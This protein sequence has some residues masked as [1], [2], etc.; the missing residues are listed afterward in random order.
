MTSCCCAAPSS[1]RRR[2]GLSDGSREPRSRRRC[3]ESSSTRATR[4]SRPAT[5][6]SASNSRTI[7]QGPGRTRARAPALHPV[8]SNVDVDCG[9]PVR[10]HL[11]FAGFLLR[12]NSRLKKAEDLLADRDA[13]LAD[14]QGQVN[15]KQAAL[16]RAAEALEAALASGQGS[17]R[18]RQQLPPASSVPPSGRREP[19][20][21]ARGEPKRCAK[22][23][24]AGPHRSRLGH[25]CLLL[26]GRGRR[27]EP[28][29]GDEGRGPADRR[30]E[31]ADRG[32]PGLQYAPVICGGTSA[33][34]P[35]HGTGQS[36]RGL[37]HSR[38]RRAS[39]S[40]RGQP[41][42]GVAP[43]H[44]RRPGPGAGGRSLGTRTAYYL[45][46]FLCAAQ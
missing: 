27:P 10:R 33:R 14:L 20:G 5:A 40:Q 29:A 2:H 38:G 45:S 44:R 35:A 17:P 37:W 12:T 26:P 28:G 21:A 3:I 46:V 41:G 23:G 22:P 43:F 25:R 42:R 8:Q 7:R 16:T 6:P 15:D 9:G 39:G 1:R 4:R 30:T 34:P 11:L 19:A 18:R 31:P 24:A 32:G 13:N 36:A